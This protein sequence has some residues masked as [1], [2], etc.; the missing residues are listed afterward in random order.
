[1]MTPRIHQTAQLSLVMIIPGT[2]HSFDVHGSDGVETNCETVE[3]TIPIDANVE[4]SDFSSD[5]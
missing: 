5:S 4:I 3:N 1:M 2:E